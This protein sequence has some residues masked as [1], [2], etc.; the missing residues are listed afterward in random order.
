M[1][2]TASLFLFCKLLIVT[3]VN[4]DNLIVTT[5]SGRVQGVTLR[6]L[7]KNK[8]YIAYRGIPYAHP[9]VGDLRFKAPEPIA[10]WQGVLQATDYANSC[11]VVY[12]SKLYPLNNTQSEDCLYLNV[13]TPVTQSK[14][15]N[16]KKAVMF[17]IH[18]GAFTEG[19]G[20]DGFYGADFIVED[21][22][23]L[24]TINYRLGPWGFASFDLKG[25][26]GN[27]GFKDQQM[28][29][30]WIHRNIKYFGGDT[31]R[32]TV[33]GESAGG[34]AVHL[35]ML[36]SKSRNLMKRAIA[37]SG[38]AL[39]TFA[40]YEPNNHVELFK[41]IF[42]LDAEATGHDVLQFVLNAPVEL[43]LEKTPIIILDRNVIGLY[44]TS[45]IE[46]ITKAENPFLTRHPRDIYRTTNVNVDA[47]FGVTNAEYMVL[48]NPAD[49]YSWI[50][51]MK[52]YS[53]IGLPFTGLT[54]STDSPEYLEAV[55]KIYKFYF[56]DRQLEQTVENVD[57]FLDMCSD[58]NFVYPSYQSLR[59]H[60]ARAKTYCYEN[61]L[62]LNL[63]AIQITENIEYL[64]G[65]GHFEDLQYLF[66]SKKYAQLYKNVLENLDD[67]TNRKTLRALEFVTAMFTNYAKNGRPSYYGKYSGLCKTCNE[68]TNDGI[69]P[70]WGLR[71]QQME[72]WDTIYDSVKRWIVNPF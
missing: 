69:K 70:M 1:L 50:E 55:K 66:L 72:F 54:L 35:Q 56:G 11:L 63:N 31:N 49:P 65:M 43:I 58:M 33:F 30:E 48:F 32:I 45:V 42:G 15:V 19:D 7:L 36:S 20:T 14:K 59:L 68:I 46:D 38:S 22:V 64:D 27:M 9:P 21:D 41:Q 67:P 61:K 71:K 24:V 8:E 16:A 57:I 17:F 23:V 25:Y 34:A 3:T 6:T 28:A 29:L 51:P 5:N 37:M 13:F 62:D 18:G 44:F 12:Q 60:S 47:M 40:H 10:P 26:T 2:L 4:C 39:T 52:N 53:N